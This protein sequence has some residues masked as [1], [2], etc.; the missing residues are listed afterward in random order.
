V[1]HDLSAGFTWVDAAEKGIRT[2]AVY[3]GLLLLLRAA[4]KRQLAQ[5][6]TFDLVVL[7]LLSNVV[8]N[9]VIGNDNTLVGGLVGAG[10][11]IAINYLVV[12]FI[13]L[14]PRIERDLRGRSTVLVENGR[15]RG[16][17][18]R[19]ELVSRSELDDALRRQGYPGLEAV[20][21]V[22]LEPEGT[23]AVRAKGDQHTIDEVLEALARIE[24]KLETGGNDSA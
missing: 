1:L 21:E 16:R 18:M 15:V 22:I 17:A 2:V 5:F 10:I 7:L 24:R 14:D 4:G 13:F 6:N 11:L 20:E 23:L 19:R 12:F 3:G 9:A 8:Q